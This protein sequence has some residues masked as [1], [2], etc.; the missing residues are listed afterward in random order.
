MD[1]LLESLECRQ[2]LRKTWDLPYH[3]IQIACYERTDD[4]K[5]VCHEILEEVQGMPEKLD[6]LLPKRNDAN[7]RVTNFHE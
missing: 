3:E 1:K 6:Q 4:L 2:A 7:S 5:K